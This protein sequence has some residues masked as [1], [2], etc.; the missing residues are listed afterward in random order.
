M[1]PGGQAVNIYATADLHGNLPEPPQDADIIL[2]AGDICPDFKA[3][4]NRNE[5]LDTGGVRQS[6]WLDEEFREWL[7]PI[8]DNGTRVFACWGNH[9]FVGES[10]YLVP[11]LPWKLLNDRGAVATLIDGGESLSIWGT[12]WVP[13][14]PRWAF[15][16][17]DAVLEM[18][19]EIIPANI[20]IIMSH[21]PPRMYGD[22]IPTRRSQ[23][24]RFGNGN[25]GDQSL[26]DA[27]VR[28]EPQYVVCGHIHEA[29]GTYGMAEA[30]TVVANVSAVDERYNLHDEPFTKLY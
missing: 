5:I 14:L 9:D 2:L 20:D 11:E 18:R 6:Q 15:Y 8:T 28:V 24:G 10:P 3:Y 22:L 13:G 29:R 1:R 17:S 16:A 30:M 27:I 4:G 26:I 21:G 23:Y 7:T 25:V 12:P 19:A